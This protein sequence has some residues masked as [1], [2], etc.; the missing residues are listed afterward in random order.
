MEFLLDLLGFNPF[1][2][3]KVEKLL[4]DLPKKK[5]GWTL[6]LLDCVGLL[7]NVRG[8]MLIQSILRYPGHPLT[9][10]S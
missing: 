3:I 5:S 1:F 8:M 9:I 10:R 4:S 6:V 2:W 7:W